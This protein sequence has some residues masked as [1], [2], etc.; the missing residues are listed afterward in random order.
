MLWS[1]P[2]LSYIYSSP[3]VGDCDGDGNLE[4]VFGSLDGKVYCIDSTNGDAKWIHQTKG[5]VYSSPALATKNRVMPY[6]VEWSMFRNSTSRTGFYNK[7]SPLGLDVI[8]GSDDGCLYLL[9][10]KTGNALNR[11][12]VKFPVLTVARKQR[13]PLKFISSPIVADIDGDR[14]L[15][16][17]FT[18]VDRMVCVTDERR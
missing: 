4:I 14:K 13:G 12:T 1:Y 9:D 17:I 8:I 15:D 6:Q 16:I 18:L 5:K 3:A 10:G 7:P 2:T 11:L